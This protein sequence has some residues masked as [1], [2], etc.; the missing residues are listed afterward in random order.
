MKNRIKE[1]YFEWMY[2][3]VC[4]DRYNR[5]ISYRKLLT[6][7]HNTEFIYTI[8]N[9]S[10]RAEDGYDLRYRYEYY[11]N[12]DDIERYISG[13]SS[14][15]EMILA[16]A[17]RCEESIMDDPAKGNR[18]GQWFWMMINNLG[19]GGMYDSNFDAEYVDDV[20]Y[21]FINHKYEP[22]GRGGLFVIRD[23]EYDMRKLEIW[24]Q[25][26]YFTDTIE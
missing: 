8:R 24:D 12:I 3:L 1:D 26:C 22:D 5:D 20:V 16:L 4:K 13:P 11:E 15:F 10:N 6:H 21:R 23:C 14:I 7:L 18:T 19:L 9:D 17:I 2:G 25:L